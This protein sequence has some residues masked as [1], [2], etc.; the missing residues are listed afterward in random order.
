MWCGAHGG[1]VRCSSA[2]E[3]FISPGFWGI[4]R[5]GA[6]SSYKL[7]STIAK[8]PHSTCTCKNYSSNCAIKDNPNDFCVEQLYVEGDLCGVCQEHFTSFPFSIEC[9]RAPERDMH[10]LMA[11][12]VVLTFICAFLIVLFRCKLWNGFRIIFIILYALTYINYSFNFNQHVHTLRAIQMLQSLSTLNFYTIYPAYKD[13]KFTQV[14]LIGLYPV[15]HNPSC[16]SNFRGFK[17]D[18]VQVSSIYIPSQIQT[19]AISFPRDCCYGI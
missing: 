3:V 1:I 13:L 2:G 12:Y 4:K 5:Q 7:T 17:H 6:N 8:C 16:L 18:F 15:I 14:E 9:V 19:K 10:E 11:A